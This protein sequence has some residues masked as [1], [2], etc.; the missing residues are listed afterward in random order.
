MHDMT[1]ALTDEQKALKAAV[2]DLCKQYPAEYWR[3]LDAKREYP[4]ALRQRADQGRLP[5]GPHP[6]RS[7]A[8][9]GSASWRA[10]SSSRRST[11][12]AATPAAC[13][14]QMYIMGTVL[15]HGSEAQKKRRTCRRSPPASCGCRPS[16]SPSP[17][18]ART[19]PSCR[20]RRS[21]RATATWSTARRCSSRAC[22]SPTSCCC[23][24]AP[25][26]WTRSRR[27]PTGSASSSSTS[28]QLKGKGL[29][30]RPLKMMMNHST[31]A[32][33][34]DNME[35]PADEPHR[36]GGQGLLLHPRRHERRAHPGR[37]RLPRRRA[38]VH[39][40]GGGLREP[41]RDLRQADR[42]QPGRAVPDRQGAHGHR[43][44]RSHAH[45]GGAHVR[46]GHPVRARGQHGQVPGL[47]G[48]HRGGQRLH[49]LPRRLRLRGGVRHRAQV[50]R[51]APLPGGARS[52][53]TSSSP[54]SG[55]T[56]SACRGRIE[57]GPHLIPLSP[58][59]RG[60]GEGWSDEREQC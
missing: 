4:E 57:G 14:A 28:A 27:R 41:A 11:A 55:S 16:A 34:F 18:R 8:A 50:P 44:R 13:H 6:A 2:Y 46:R 25:P 23:S 30:V 53:T 49:R 15:R 3:E 40:E 39:R 21:A 43:G 29:D 9:A 36:P 17:T 38:L 24:P 48:G 51:V 60:Q 31:N 22:S 26:R 54:T 42:R 56:S 10:R 20:P 35:I 33:F 37:L 1:F 5:R 32:L 59:G 58:Q 47:R 7:T 19:P 45:Q 52:T 12:R